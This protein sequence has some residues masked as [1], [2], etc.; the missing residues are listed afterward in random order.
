MTDAITAP[1]LFISYSWTSPDHE[2]WVLQ[3]ATELRESGID[4]IFDKWD[5]REGHDAHAFMEQMVT[6]S[7]IERVILVCDQVYAEKADDRAGGVGTET[8]I[9]TPDIYARQDQ[10][11]FVAVVTE[12]DDDNRP[13]LPAF[14]GSRIFID[15]SDPATRSESF[16]RLLRW[17]FGQPL[18]RKPPLGAKPA[19]L[20]D[21]ERS[22]VLATSS[23]FSRSVDAVRNARPNALALVTEYLDVLAA[24]LEKFRLQDTMD[25]DFDEAFVQNIEAFLPYRNEAIEVFRQLALNDSGEETVRIVH[26]FFERLI[27]YLHRPPDVTSWHEHDFD[28]FGFIVP[29][30]FLY[31]L[32]CFLRFERFTSAASLIA[33]DYYLSDLSSEYGTSTI[34]FEIL[35]PYVATFERRNARLGLKRVSLQANL[36]KER[37]R[38]AGLSFGDVMQA[39]LIL[40]FRSP[41]ESFRAPSFLVAAHPAIRDSCSKSV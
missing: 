17:A 6:D 15:M 1:K 3:L 24:E 7:T 32:A 18:H 35:G 21:E 38:D 12:R 26:R 31:A 19:F 5:L 39:D 29:E 16:D 9:I 22:L 25:E 23:R 40:F 4:V 28:N 2:A 27:P 10:D 20:V 30:M 34:S 11:K 14:Y 37:S 33:T 13:C 41:N 8:L 36:L